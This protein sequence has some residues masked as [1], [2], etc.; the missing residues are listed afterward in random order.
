MKRW[1]RYWMTDYRTWVAVSLVFGLILASDRSDT[2]P[3]LVVGLVA[4]ALIAVVASLLVIGVLRVRAHRAAK[5]QAAVE[6]G[7]GATDTPGTVPSS[8]SGIRAQARCVDDAVKVI[9]SSR[10]GVL[11]GKAAIYELPWYLVVGSPQAGK[12]SAIANSGLD[13]P[14]EGER[15]ASTVAD[16]A[17]VCGWHFTK[18]GILLDAPGRYATDAGAHAEWMSLLGLLKKHRSRAPLNGMVVAVSLVELMESTSSA[19]VD[20]AR[21]LRHRLQE[22]TERLEVFAPVYVMF[23]KADALPGFREFFQG[24]EPTERQR[25][26]GATLPYGG[27]GTTGAASSFD[28][29]FDLLIAG[30]QEAAVQQMGMRRGQ[31]ISPGLLSLP[32]EF[33]E[34]RPLLNTFISTLFEDNPYQFR[35]IF[36]GF[37]F[38]SS[39][40]QEAIR[41]AA[42]SRVVQRFGLSP[43]AAAPMDEDAAAAGQPHFL[44][45]VFRKVIFFDR[46]LVRQYVNPRQ[47]RLR[48][49]SLFA[50]LG[51]LAFA[52]TAWTWSYTANRQLARNAAADLAK[53]A[54]LQQGRTD[55]K[56]RLDALL[57]LHDRL[58][59]LREYRHDHPLQLGLGLYQ[60]ERIEAKLRQEYFHGMRQVMLV[61][62]TEQLESFLQDVIAHRAALKPLA[63][64]EARAIEQDAVSAT[65]DGLYQ[66]PVATQLDDAYNALKT[67]LMLGD[68]AHL[69]TSH[70][71]DQLTRFWRD[72]L[73]AHRGT[74]SNEAMSRAAAQLLSLYVAESDQPT[75]PLIEPRYT[76]VEQARSALGSVMRGA[77][78]VERVY[79]QIKQRASMRFGQVTVAGLLGKDAG[80]V[81]I[82]GAHVVP[83]AFT[84]EAWTEYV[85]DAIKEASTSQLSSTDWVLE[86]TVVRDLSMAGSPEH[87]AR[88][89]TALYKRDYAAEWLQFLRGV[90]LAPFGTF[91]QAV[92]RM[93]VLGD[94]LHSPL[95]EL[96]TAV[97][98]ETE[99]DAPSAA[100]QGKAKARAGLLAWVHRVILRRTG[101]EPAAEAAATTPV[102]SPIATAFQGVSRLMVPRDGGS[103]LLDAYVASLGSLRGRLNQIRNEGDVGAGSRRLMQD[104]FEGRQ[105]DIADIATLVD[106]QMLV[107][108]PDNQRDALR[109]LLLRPAASTFAALVP[110]SEADLNR[111]WNEQVYRPFSDG[112]GQ[113][114]PFRS[115]A[116]M[117]AAQSDIDQM[118]G[119]SGAIARFG[120]DSLGLLV[121][122]R[123]NFLTPRQWGGMGITL[124]PAFMAGYPRWVAGE[125]GARTEST[126]VFEVLPLPT[127]G[128][129]Y[130]LT[131]DGVSLRYRNTEP[132][133]KV[134]QTPGPG[135]P[136][137]RVS[138]V[139]LDGSTV[140]LFN[141]AGAKGVARL[142][143]AGKPAR[144]GPDRYRMTF[145]SG[146]TQ[147]SFELRM[148]SAPQG[149][150]PQ[151]VGY[152]GLQLPSVIA[153]ADAPPV[154]AQPS[155]VDA[156]QA[157][158]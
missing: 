132:Q 26:W 158:R 56:S 109:S 53:A 98:R 155:A 105:S 8:A 88:E 74:M 139:A 117:E 87:V 32:M 112:I 145:G 15:E 5:R 51:L 33:A 96:L 141:Q 69:E 119:A 62:V 78:A 106:Q 146:D 103:S 48:Y 82:T 83:G 71:G 4:V 116:S 95:R 45:D 16:Q 14:I 152:K 19:V 1:L 49:V 35:P 99:W 55:L 39:H 97:H 67:Y 58:V 40:P 143:D 17:Q 24:M 21:S 29:H 156:P 134:F 23:T 10:L 127:S 54:S 147:V 107:G 126:T 18:E 76:L 137:V 9:K 59:Q 148:V 130:N 84:R 157:R 91:D 70:L 92:E 52:L 111:S 149:S 72:W 154:T 79:A 3:T 118:F 80:K 27:D 110:P 108:M 142:F 100:A 144:L 128:R 57:V 73:N 136:G 46:E 12:S 64:D 153:G 85:Q 151:A 115:G 123:G 60:G 93:G 36:R 13:F 41:H 31:R 133:W 7:D 94:P 61:P 89:L 102:D 63:S 101:D 44:H 114:Y 47:L 6:T 25:A 140:E 131:V 28:A 121:V 38:T 86:Q 30:L 138:A 113:Q 75:W 125:G 66:A 129:E 104:T 2:L 120:Q 150:A 90:D 34:L 81:Q 43:G 68:R 124:T 20:L 37:Y 50:G 77:P 42:W 11:K 135:A 65:S 122:R 22:S